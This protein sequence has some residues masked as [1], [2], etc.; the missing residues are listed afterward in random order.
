MILYFQGPGGQVYEP[1]S[2]DACAGL[3]VGLALFGSQNFM[4]FL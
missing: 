1:L 2:E 3:A 4:V